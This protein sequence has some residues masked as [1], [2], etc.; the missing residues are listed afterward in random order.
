M[1]RSKKITPDR[2]TVDRLRRSLL[3]RQRALF[4]EVDGVEE[5]LRTI[6]EAQES[7]FEE[8][9][10]LETMDRLLDRVRERDR[11]TLEEIH[12]ALV[13]IPT[14][15]YGI[16]EGCGAA[17]AVARLQAVPETRWCI[18]CAGE[19]EQVRAVPPRSFEPTAHRALP[20]EFRELDDTELA[21]AVRERLRNHGDPD[22]P[23]V[24][25][26]CH[27]GVVRLSG[28]IPGEPQRQVLRQIIQDGMGLDLI[29]RV[30]V[31]GVDREFRGE[32]ER[33]PGEAQN[34]EERIP[35]GR[36]MRPLGAER[37]RVPEDEGQPSETPAEGPIPE[38]E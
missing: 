4:D 31:V 32:D 12:R 36:G 37:P 22:L 35:A 18:E 30:R 15:R 10:Q 5:D 9:G 13:K 28:T 14:G 7:E 21:E 8:R 19:R 2:P 34:A 11:Q 24:S 17:V 23:K 1:S 33:L 38:E 3:A 29:D 27:G 25:V 16:C 20:E 26:R 6:E